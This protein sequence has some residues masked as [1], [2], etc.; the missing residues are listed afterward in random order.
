MQAERIQRDTRAILVSLADL[1]TA[2]AAQPDR[3]TSSPAEQA[4]AAELAAAGAALQA[5]IAGGPLSEPR[6]GGRP[7]PD[8][9]EL[10][11]E[12]LEAVAVRV[13]RALDAW[14]RAS[15]AEQ[16]RLLA[17]AQAAATRSCA[18]LW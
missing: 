13:A 10:Y 9:A 3:P 5:A 12:Q 15:G 4:A 1:A 17:L 11:T 14:S 2:Q 18:Y 6:S 8:A 7:W 16:E